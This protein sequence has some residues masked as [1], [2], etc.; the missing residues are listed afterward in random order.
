MEYGLKVFLRELIS[1]FYIFTYQFN[2]GVSFN[3]CAI[4]SINSC[5]TICFTKLNSE[6]QTIQRWFSIRRSSGHVLAIDKN[7]K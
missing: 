5:E 4:N 3:L 1:E 7:N 6:A 2:S